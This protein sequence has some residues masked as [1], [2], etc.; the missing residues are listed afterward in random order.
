METSIYKTI[1]TYLLELISR[2]VNTPNY[3]LPSERML[4][5]NFNVSRK[6][7]RHAYDDLID[8]GYVTRI[9]GSGY[10]ISSSIDADQLQSSFQKRIKISFI[11]PAVT[12]QYSHALL[13]GVS[14][15]CAKNR[16]E[17]TIH[18]SDDLPEKENSLIRSASKTG[19]MG[20]ILFP[21]DNDAANYN[22]LARLAVRKFPFVLVDR[23]IPNFNTSF[24]ASDDHQSMIDALQF[25]FQ[26]GYHNPVFVTP[27]PRSASSIDSRINGYTHGLLRFY[28]MASPSNL[29]ILSENRS[30]HKNE[31]MQHL[32]KYPQTD[33]MILLGTKKTPVISALKGMGKNA[34]KLML[35]DDELSH[36]E[37]ETLK[38]FFI[39]Q[40][41]YSIGYVA[42]EILYNHILGDMRPSVRLFPVTIAD[43]DGN[44]LMPTEPIRRGAEPH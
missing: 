35:F 2:N 17:Y 8:R 37:R 39:L 16:V 24:V 32:Q 7:V 4:A 21:A 42:A 33:V 9:H 27:S 41:G 40:D 26:R 3:K 20:I 11:I 29:L 36:T 31:V 14:D 44:P 13:S 38:P 5:T 30:Q 1:T 23:R 15:F 22:E 34:I 12:T 10:Y 28:K 43:A 6:P 19:S 18:V 25:L